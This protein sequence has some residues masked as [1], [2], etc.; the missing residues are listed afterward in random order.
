MT[1]NEFFLRALDI[2]SRDTTKRLRDEEG[3]RIPFGFGFAEFVSNQAKQ[4][5]DEHFKDDEPEDV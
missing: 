4:I 3:A 5:T 1:R 2:M